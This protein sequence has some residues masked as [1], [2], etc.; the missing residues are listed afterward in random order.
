M[1]ILWKARQK[2]PSAGY[3]RT[4]LEPAGAGARHLPRPR[5]Q[6]RQ[7][8]GRAQP[9]RAG[10]RSAQALAGRLGLH[11]K[12]AYVDGDDLLPRLDELPAG[13][14]P[15]RP[16]G[17][18]PAAGR[19]RRQAGHRERLP[20]RLGHRRGAGRRG[21]HRRLPPGHRRLAGRRPGG[22]VARLGAR[23][24]RR[25]GRARSRPGTSSSAGRRRPAATTR[26]STRSAT[27]ATR[28][29][30]SPRSPRD[31][32]SVITK[33]PGTGGL[34]SV[35]TVTAQL[36][37]EIAE[38]AY[39][40]PDVDR[41]LRHDHGSSA[42]GPDRVRLVRHAGQ[43]AAGHGE[44]RDQL[45]RRLPQHHDAGAD[46]P[47]HRGEGGLGASRSCSASS[48]AED[49]FDEVDVRL[50]RFDRPDAPT[51]EQAT[52]HLRI[53]VKDPDPRQGRPARSPT[54]PWSWRWAG[55]P[56]STRPPRRPRRAPSACTG[57]RSC[58]A[59]AV[60]ARGRVLPDGT[61]VAIPP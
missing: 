35:G 39:A 25:A 49:Q 3:A 4:V 13:G 2:D 32:S 46:R 19:G 14:Q 6:D 17:H 27:A 54:R 37:Y 42:D 36:L 30:R 1:L 44:G 47:G 29:S 43:P 9:G 15:L 57:P 21:R 20:R 33:H 51:N 59:G 41:A 56:A 10:R 61:S 11:P 40:N 60:A 18:R 48:A 12:I 52:A 53:T 34:V 38:P 50:L 58:P 31:G 7:Q 26:S 24:L 45:P 22:L 8:R 5:H 23:R 28:A 55:T 16:P